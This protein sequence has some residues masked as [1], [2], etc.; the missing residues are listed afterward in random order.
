LNL[1]HSTI[2]SN[3]VRVPAV[4]LRTE[5]CRRSCG[6]ERHHGGRPYRL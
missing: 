3:L 2:V 6:R 4:H 5:L 1:K